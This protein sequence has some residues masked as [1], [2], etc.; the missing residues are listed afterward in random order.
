MC[1]HLCICNSGCSCRRSWLEF[2]INK[3]YQ[4]IIH[5]I[6]N[7]IINKNNKN[8]DKRKGDKKQQRVKLTTIWYSFAKS[9]DFTK[10]KASDTLQ[11]KYS[12]ISD[13]KGDADGDRNSD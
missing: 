11:R 13:V 5:G 7:I 8:T 3:K 6:K 10:K 4:F 9:T 1:G 2:F 12:E